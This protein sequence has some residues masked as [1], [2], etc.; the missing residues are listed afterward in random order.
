MVYTVSQIAKTG[1][2]KPS[3]Q[4]IAPIQVKID[5]NGLEANAFCDTGADIYLSIA[6]EF[7]GL[8][9]HIN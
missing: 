6:S 2:F 4:F 9:R 1:L 3:N 8:N 7:A 5:G